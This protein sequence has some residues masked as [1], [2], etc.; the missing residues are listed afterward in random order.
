MCW[1]ETKGGGNVGRL[2]SCNG[3]RRVRRRDVE[4]EDRRKIGLVY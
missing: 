2:G 4:K 3:W 1:C